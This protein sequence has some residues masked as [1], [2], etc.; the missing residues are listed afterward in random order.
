M[1]YINQ[2]LLASIFSV[3]SFQLLAQ[4][5]EAFLCCNASGDA[6]ESSTLITCGFSQDGSFT[7]AFSNTVGELE[8]AG[9]WDS[10]RSIPNC[11]APQ[12][13][14]TGSSLNTPWA[15][16]FY[17]WCGLQACDPDPLGL[18]PPPSPD[19][20]PVPP[21]PRLSLDD[22]EEVAEEDDERK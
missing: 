2:I 22:E 14:G 8:A 17:G 9:T 3:V 6:D 19:P 5:S 18:N 4:E 15:P 7:E 13:S 11:S 1:K 16:F 21:S 20:F 10:I 12:P